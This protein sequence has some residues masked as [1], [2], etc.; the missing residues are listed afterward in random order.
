MNNFNPELERAAQDG[1]EWMFGAVETDLALVPLSIRLLFAPK[2]VPQFNLVMDTNGC[3]SRSPLN[4]CETKFTYFYNTTMHPACKKWLEDNKYIVDGK[5]VFNDA[6]I[7]ILSGT[8]PQG[9]SLKAPIDAIRKNGLIP[10]YML[11]LDPNA[12][13]EQYMDKGRITQAMYDLAEEFLKRFT[14]NYEQ[15]DNKKF[16]AAL[17]EDLLAVAGYAWPSPVGGIYPRTEGDF[18]HAFA[19]VDPDIDAL[20]NY[21]P[22]IKKLAKDYL[23]FE[24]GYTLSITAQ[25]PYPAETIALFDILQKYGLLSFFAEAWSRLVAS[26]LKVSGLRR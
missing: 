4:I 6:F 5:V 3:A 25:N 12:T 24:W 11:P 16:A 13:W 19:T 23:F 17:Q 2:G 15:V 7:E 22:F 9:N 8:T 21:D 10:A 20:D 1:S 26:G 14:I 18:N